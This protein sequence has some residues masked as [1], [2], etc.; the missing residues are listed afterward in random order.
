M[1]VFLP[2]QHH[3][4][5]LG[6]TDNGNLKELLVPYHGTNSGENAS[7]VPTAVTGQAL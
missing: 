2:E 3:A 6:E 7:S 1:P 5:W 4:V